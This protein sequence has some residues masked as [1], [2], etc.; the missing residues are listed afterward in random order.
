MI[1]LLQKVDSSE[2]THCPVV[3]TQ[4]NIS[5]SVIEILFQTIPKDLWGQIAI[6]PANLWCQIVMGNWSNSYTRL[7][8]SVITFVVCFYNFLMFLSWM[9]APVFRVLLLVAFSSETNR[10]RKLC[11]HCHLSYRSCESN[12]MHVRSH[13]HHRTFQVRNMS[14]NEISDGSKIVI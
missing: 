4:Y 13:L 11:L 5:S 6:L 10:Q 9:F 1:Q 8:F 2:S 14:S 3:R 12:T 7:P